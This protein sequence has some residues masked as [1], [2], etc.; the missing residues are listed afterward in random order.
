MDETEEAGQPA[1]GT[2]Q[3][4]KTTDNV[5]MASQNDIEE[6]IEESSQ[7]PEGCLGVREEKYRKKKVLVLDLDETLVHSSFKPVPNADFIVPIVI[8]GIT[9]NV[10]VLKRPFVDEFLQE[11]AKHFE[12]VI[13]TASLG[14][15]ANPLLDIL[16]PPEQDLIQHRLFRET[17]VMHNGTYVKDLGALGRKLKDQIFVDN[18]PLSYQFHPNNAVNITSWFDDPS[19]TELRDLLPVLCGKLKEVPDVRTILDAY[20]KSFKW[21]CA[22]ADT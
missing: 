18:S 4:V 8:E 13:F 10:Y 1:A 20:N 2:K 22:Q 15:Y 14:V 17:C 6:S 9:Y 5:E 19:D 3:V 16:A 12:V 21:L 7:E 11:C